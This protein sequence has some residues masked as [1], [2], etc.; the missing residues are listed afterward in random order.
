MKKQYEK[1]KIIIELF[2]EQDVIVCSWGE[3]PEDPGD[4]IITG[5]G[6]GLDDA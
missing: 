3:N 2:S 4:D 5:N 1:P 6:R